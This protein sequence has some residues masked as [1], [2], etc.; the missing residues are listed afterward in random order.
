MY[1]CDIVAELSLLEILPGDL[2]QQN[3]IS[4]ITYAKRNFSYPKYQRRR[5]RLRF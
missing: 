5:L 3:L 4:K 1:K 2:E